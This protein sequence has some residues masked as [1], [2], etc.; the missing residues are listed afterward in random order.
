MISLRAFE[1][2][3]TSPREIETVENTIHLVRGKRVMLDSDLAAIY[4]VST[5]RLNEQVRRNLKRFPS[6]FAFRLTRQEFTVLISQFAIS[7]KGRG[8]RRTLPW[9]FTEHGAIML[10]S[11]LKSDIAVEAS[12]RVVRAFVRLR[13]IVSANAGLAAKFAQ[14]ERRLDSHDEAIAQLFAAIRQLLAPP[15]EKK[16]EIGFHVRERQ[17]RYRA[18]GRS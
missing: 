3:M 6:D 13:E 14:L 18:K 12:V 2:P 15:P 5:M 9:A 4:G 10:A 17:A 11:I 16:R 8:G 1:S 7:K